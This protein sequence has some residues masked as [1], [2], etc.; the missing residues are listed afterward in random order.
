MFIQVKMTNTVK[1]RVMYAVTEIFFLALVG[2]TEAVQTI[3][4]A[5]PYVLIS[6]H[7]G[8]CRCRNF[9]CLYRNVYGN[10]SD[11]R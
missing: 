1:C 8:T 3:V 10:A 11:P 5:I 6:H 2:E 7:E 4:K 9:D